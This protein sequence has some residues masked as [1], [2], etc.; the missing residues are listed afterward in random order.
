MTGQGYLKKD[1]EVTARD[2]TIVLLGLMGGRIIDQ[3]DVGPI[4]LKRLTVLLV[5]TILTSDSRVIL[6]ITNT[7][8]PGETQGS[9]Y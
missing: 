6:A 2:G 7:G 1:I 8:V 4:L 3:L 5:S 9:I